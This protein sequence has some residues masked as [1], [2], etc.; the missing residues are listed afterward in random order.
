MLLV[1]ITTMRRCDRMLKYFFNRDEQDVELEYQGDKIIVKIKVPDNFQHDKLIET[2]TEMGINGE[3]HIKTPELIEE[4]IYRFIKE[5]SFEIPIDKTLDK[6][7]KWSDASQ[8][9]KRFAIR[10]MD[11]QLRDLIHNQIGFLGEIGEEEK[12]NSEK[13]V[14]MEE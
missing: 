5:L 14:T 3:I 12:G 10:V 8:K 13:L 7:I 4:R 6:S 9:Q 1:Q 2:F 11:P